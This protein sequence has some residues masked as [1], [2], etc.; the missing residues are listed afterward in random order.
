MRRVKRGAVRLLLAG[1]LI[2]AQIATAST[3][4]AQSPT[5]DPNRDIIITGQVPPLF[6]DIT[7]ERELD[8]DAIAGYDLST[9]DELLGELG[10]ELGDDEQPLILVNGERVNDVDQIGAFPVE[11]LRNVQVLPRGSAVRLGGRSGQRVI[12]LT[13]HRQA[14]SATLTV[15]PKIATD[16]DWHSNRGEAIGTYVRGSTRANLTLRVRDDSN[17]LESE[18]DIIQPQPRLPYALAGNI[19]GYPDTLRE[20]DP[21]LSALAGEIVT[22]APIP[23][24]ANPTLADFVANAN[25]AAVTDIGEF[26]TLR[27]AT[28]NYD[29]NG[30]VGT[31]LA[32]WLTSTATIR[33]SRNLSRL[34][35]GLPSALFILSPDNP[36]SP[37]SD[38]V[39]LAYYGTEPLHSRSRRDS[40]NGNLTLNGTFG[41][42]TA[43]FNARHS[44]SNDVTRT[45]RQATS[46]ISLDDSIDPFSADLSD[47]IVLRTDKFTSRSVATLAQLTLDGPAAKLP[48]GNLQ[49]VFEGRL[50]WNRQRSD[51]SFSATDE[52]RKFRRSEQSIRGAV[53]V[54]LASRENGFL[55]ELGELSATAEFSRIHYSDAGSLSHHALG[56]TWEPR[57]PLRLGALIEET[58]RPPSI[59]ILGN[60]VIVTPDVRVFDPLTGET[61][62]VVQI[63]GGNPDIRAEKTTIRRVNGLLRLVPRLNLQLNAEYTDTDAR[64]F[65]SS[66]PSAS[67]AVTLAFPDRFIRDANGVLTTVDLRP[68][69]FDSHRD[70]RLRWGFSLNARLDGARDSANPTLRS[71]GRT[72][73]SQR[74]SL[75]LTV[76]HTIVFSDKISIR[77][78]LDLVNLLEGGAIGI[79]SGR[80]RHQLDGTAALTSGGLGIRAG[81]NWR[82]KSTLESRIGGVTDTL[83]FSPVLGVSL[84]AFADMKRIVPHSDWARGLRLSL[85]VANLTNDRQKVRDSFGNTPLQYQPGYREPIG[86]TVEFELRKVF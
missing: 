42:W 35:R 86:R 72:P 51:S 10:G 45:E 46:T 12:S 36:F 76:N 68:V 7:P 23:A 15:A 39:A 8:E 47:L 52:P 71:A 43:N 75:Q 30:T 50:A 4:A 2:P 48:A 32:P 44:R 56:L 65:V 21:L 62:D 73:V 59:Q 28:R 74:K 38:D 49:T 41:S 53:D 29:L 58:G 33:L 60:P 19:I 14:R 67:A 3:G 24:T 63:T 66:L 77:P 79:A 1:A 5:T 27:P 34:R 31:R 26:R 70:K 9:I 18:R 69:N 61:V 64:H 83:R 11:V 25:D 6:R 85:N 40:A 78:G 13:L 80:V 22:V 37:F 55:P 57:P 84:R 20:I 16:G 81:V 82:G 17:L 54:P